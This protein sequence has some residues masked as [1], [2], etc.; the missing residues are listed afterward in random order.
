[1]ENLQRTDWAIYS[2][3]LSG[4]DAGEV[5]EPPITLSSC[6]PMA[7]KWEA[8]GCD[9]D[10]TWGVDPGSWFTRIELG[11]LKQLK[12]KIQPQDKVWLLTNILREGLPNHSPLR[13]QLFSN[14]HPHILLIT[15][16]VAEY[17]ELVT[18]GGA[19]PRSV[20]DTGKAFAHLW[21][22]SLSLPMQPLRLGSDRDLTALNHTPTPS[23][24][25]QKPLTTAD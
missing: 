16:V 24:S 10:P 6:L 11:L 21:V 18:A 12:A 15:A 17:P 9:E 13:L 5:P 22:L 25:N 2:N 20:A 23:G 7:L 8:F 4:E 14:Q 19:S 3:Y 1:M